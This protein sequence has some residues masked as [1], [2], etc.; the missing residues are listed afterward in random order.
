MHSL[1]VCRGHVLSIKACLRPGLWKA[2]WWRTAHSR[3]L[4]LQ[5]RTEMLE[6]LGD[7]DFLAKLHCIR[8]A[9]QVR[10][11]AGGSACS[12][13]QQGRPLLCPPVRRA[14]LQCSACKGR[15]QSAELLPT[16]TRSVSHHCPSPHLSRRSVVTL[17]KHSIVMSQGCGQSCLK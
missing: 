12:P 3:S 11:A 6:C 1:P 16:P 8:Q 2:C 15:G 13:C 17:S 7:S 5:C 9:F 4:L 14:A 10:L